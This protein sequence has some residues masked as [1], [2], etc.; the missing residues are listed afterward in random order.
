VIAAAELPATLALSDLGATTPLAR[1]G[2]GTVEALDDAT[3]VF[4]RFHDRRIVDGEVLR[5]FVDWRRALAVGDRGRLDRVATWPLAVVSEAGGAVGF[6]M[7]CV[8]DAFADAVRLPSG[9]QRR[10]LRE[11]QYL[12][13]PA[14]HARRLRVPAIS[15]RVRLEVVWALSET[16]A[17]LHAR[18]MVVG[19]LSTRNILW[20]PQPGQVLLVDCDSFTLGGVGSPLAATFTIDWEDPAQPSAHAA[21]ADV[22]KLGLFVLRALGR[23]FQTRDPSLADGALDATGRLLL[24]GSLDPDPA[25]RPTAGAWE[26]WAGGRRASTTRIKEHRSDA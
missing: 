5:A 14:E 6:V 1:G 23:S 7:R 12:L 8:P 13:A 2:A 9:A 17:F 4:K 20:R 26:R 22:Y 24:R 16:I 18:R 3:L 25:A 19:D 11:A 15:S 10:V 21:S